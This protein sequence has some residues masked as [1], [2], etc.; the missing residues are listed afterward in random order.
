MIAQRHIDFDTLARRSDPQTSKDAAAMVRETLGKRCAECLRIVR[1]NPGI[2]GAEV[3]LISEQARKRLGEVEARGLIRRG[4]VRV[5]ANS[6]CA[7][8]TWHVTN[9]PEPQDE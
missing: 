6:R 7:S 2:T 4:E 5:S 9:Q 1:E 3:G 8:V